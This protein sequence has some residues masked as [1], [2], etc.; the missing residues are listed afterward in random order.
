M[1]KIGIV[2]ANEISKKH[3]EKISEMKDFQLV[4]FYDHDDES[5]K[6]IENN[7]GINRFL[8][9][10]DLLTHTDAIDVL[11]PVGSHYN[12]VSGAIRKIRHVFVDKVLSENL[13]EAK[14]LNSLAEEANIQLYV[15]RYEKFHPNYQWLK[16]LA[17]NPFYI[18]SAKF[19]PNIINLSPEDLV[20]ELLLNELDLVLS[21]VKA[22]VMRVRATGA[23]LH[24]NT[25]D[26]INVRIE[27]DN[28]CIYNIVGGS[29]KSDQKNKIRFF[30]KNK[31]YSLD[32]NNFKITFLNNSA[33]DKELVVK[34]EL[35]KAS[36]KNP[37]EMI[38][39]E[40]EH[41]AGSILN[42]TLNLRTHHDNFQ[43]LELAHEIIDKL[44]IN[45]R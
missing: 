21:I 38:K 22:R 40:L 23:C 15:S 14:E 41:F 28:G 32:L 19:D 26:F 5:A 27:F 8:N 2:G 13:D 4:G 9:Y 18:E 25:I 3:I 30:Q 11:S 31:T 24:S 16:K 37:T 6:L 10:N 1:I 45:K 12:Y 44:K 43:L 36:G 35:L 34:E 39:R 7:F 20:F 17:D 42:H 29:F 33:E